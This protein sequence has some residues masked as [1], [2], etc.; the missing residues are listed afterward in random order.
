MSTPETK[1]QIPL[2]L[3]VPVG[4]PKP[5]VESTPEAVAPAEAIQPINANERIL[6]LKGLYAYV[7]DFINRIQTKRDVLRYKKGVNLRASEQYKLR[8]AHGDDIGT[9]AFESRVRAGDMSMIR[10]HQAMGAHKAFKRHGEKSDKLLGKIG[11]HKKQEY[12]PWHAE[13]VDYEIPDVSPTKVAYNGLVANV[14]NRLA[15]RAGELAEEFER[16]PNPDDKLKAKIQKQRDRQVKLQGVAQKRRLNQSRLRNNTKTVSVHRWDATAPEP[17]PAS[18]PLSYDEELLVAGT[19]HRLQPFIEQQVEA[20]VAAGEDPGYADSMIRNELQS[21]VMLD[22]KIP[23]S[24]RR[25]AIEAILELE[26]VEEKE[27]SLREQ[28]SQKPKPSQAKA[29][30]PHT[31]HY[32]SEPHTVHYRRSNQGYV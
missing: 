14:A 21:L 20:A 2:I 6:S 26:Q 16:D 13:T 15:V 23:N 12:T 19:W 9:D 4:R 8:R 25:S 3:T 22:L 1:F 10:K 28:D 27:Q 7:P 32:Q 18:E 11:S 5:V 30:K 31:V 24:K 29:S 17:T